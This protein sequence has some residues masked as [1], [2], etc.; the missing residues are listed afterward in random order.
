MISVIPVREERGTINFVNGVSINERSRH[1]DN[2]RSVDHWE[3]DLVSGP[4][5]TLVDRKSCSTIIMKLRGKM[6]Y[7]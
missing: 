4:K 7:Q 1:I 5:A 2:R 6:R 3:G